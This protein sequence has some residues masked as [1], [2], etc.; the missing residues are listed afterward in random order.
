MSGEADLITQLA[1]RLIGGRHL[2]PDDLREDAV[3]AHIGRYEVVRP[4]APGAGGR[5]LLAED[6]TLRREVAIKVLGRTDATSEARFR[7]EMQLLARLEHPGIVRVLDAGADEAGRPYFVMEHVDAPSLAD[8][9]LPLPEAV[10]VLEAVA[11]AC[12]AAHLAGLVHQRLEPQSVLVGPRPVVLDFGVACLVQAEHTAAKPGT[13]EF[14]APEQ[15]TGGRV[16]PWTDVHA[17]GALL[18]EQLTGRT[19]FEDPDPAQVLQR[20][21][22]ESPPPPRQLAP[23]APAALARLALRALAKRPADRPAALEMAH[24][25]RRW[26][27]GPRRALQLGAATLALLLVGVAAGAA[28]TELRGASSDRP[29]LPTTVTPAPAGGGPAPTSGASTDAPAQPPAPDPAA[30]APAGPSPAGAAPARPSPADSGAPAPAPAPGHPGRGLRPGPAR[31]EGSAP[32][33]SPAD[34]PSPPRG[35][36]WPPP[37]QPWLEGEPPPA[38]VEGQPPPPGVEGQP[39]PP[40]AQGPPGGQHGPPGPP[41]GPRPPGLR[42]GGRPPG[43]RPPGPPPG[44][45]GPPGPRQG[46]R[47]PPPPPP[48]GQ[49]PAPPPGG[50]APW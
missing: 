45:P 26:R 14:L 35:E 29:A 3:P 38:W 4:L 5:V 28:W 15:V 44:G 33:R 13:P 18:Y 1:T 16:G 48:E 21:E 47:P 17:L 10:R 39:P 43:A 36:G 12:H 7:R 49:E 40:W 20:I 46:Q 24:A 8:R 22:R 6:R 42:P 19:P 31:E 27:E 23:R 37:P 41:H 32:P 30:A 11:R 50:D 25:L 34:G 9:R 2:R